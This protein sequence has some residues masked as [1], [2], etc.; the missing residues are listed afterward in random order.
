MRAINFQ[1]EAV[2]AQCLYADPF[3]AALH[4]SNNK[5]EEKTRPA[6]FR[7]KSAEERQEAPEF[8]I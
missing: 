2:V 3:V 4:L 1:G 7:G 8:D 6:R 5:K